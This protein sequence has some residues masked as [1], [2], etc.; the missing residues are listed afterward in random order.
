[1]CVACVNFWG[2]YDINNIK[3]IMRTYDSEGQKTV[4][5]KNGVTSNITIVL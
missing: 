3:S 5:K 1:M 4:C 2:I